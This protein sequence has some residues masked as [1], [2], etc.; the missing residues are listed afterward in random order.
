MKKIL[1]WLFVPILIVISGYLFFF[2]AAFLAASTYYDAL[3]MGDTNSVVRL[4]FKNSS[5]ER[6]KIDQKFGEALSWDD[7]RYLTFKIVGVTFL[8]KGFNY[9]EVVV[10][11]TRKDVAGVRDYEERLVL[12]KKGLGYRVKAITFS[13]DPL[14]KYRDQDPGEN[15]TDAEKL[16]QDLNLFPAEIMEVIITDKFKHQVKFVQG[17]NDK[18][19]KIL[20]KGIREATPITHN[21]LEN[22]NYTLKIKTKSPKEKAKEVQINYSSDFKIIKVGEKIFKASPA[23]QFLMGNNNV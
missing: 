13:D 10:K 3:T 5:R 9:P 16:V 21:F 15:L 2:L 8:E 17:K 4:M 6:S 11:I 20:A 14:A 1:M 18:E 22:Y 12:E 7:S 19:I 23:L